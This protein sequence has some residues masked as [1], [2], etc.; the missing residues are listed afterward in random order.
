MSGFLT[1]EQ[2]FADLPQPDD[3]HLRALDRHHRKPRHGYD[4]EEKRAWRVALWEQFAHAVRPN[5]RDCVNV[6]MI[7]TTDAFEIKQAL[8]L[9]FLE[10]NLHVCNVNPAIVASLK[11]KYPA[12]TTYGIPA[13]RA[14]RRAQREGTRFSVISLD[15][16]GPI[17]AR[18]HDTLHAARPVFDGVGVVGLTMLR[19]R[20]P[21]GIT[22]EIPGRPAPWRKLFQTR[23]LSRAHGRDLLRGTDI[24]RIGAP[25]LHLTFGPV[26]WGPVNRKGISTISPVRPAD[27]DC[28]VTIRRAGIYPSGQLTMLWAVYSVVQPVK[29]RPRG[30]QKNR[31]EK[32][33]Q[34][35]NFPACAAGPLHDQLVRT[36][37]PLRL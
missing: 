24:M 17:S 23:F 5:C 32:G 29:W 22:L 31:P 27:E 26:S 37:A 36:V 16:C 1:R 35:F 34:E 25:F 13:E 14:L 28:V 11:R 12:V 2:V 6:F 3:Q 9:G 30:W 33:F 20:E 19:G 18:T 7:E 10:Q 21:K 8:R 15:L 4:V